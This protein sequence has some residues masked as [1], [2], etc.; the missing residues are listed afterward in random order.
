M[1]VKFK[2]MLGYENICTR[3]NNGRHPQQTRRLIAN[4]SKQTLRC[5][6]A[7]IN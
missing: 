3:S 2:K 4:R 7:K 1:L 5:V 6:R